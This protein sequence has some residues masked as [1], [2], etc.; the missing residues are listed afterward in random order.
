MLGPLG[1]DDAAWFASNS[2]GRVLGFG[3]R[4]R[5]SAR[6]RWMETARSPLPASWRSVGCV[7]CSLIQAAPQPIKNAAGPLYP[8]GWPSFLSEG[9]ADSH[10]G[11]LRSARHRIVAAAVAMTASDERLGVTGNGA[12]ERVRSESVDR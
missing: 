6:S 1:G 8:A 12:P 3:V 10:R 2:A 11:G 7:A 5:R 4:C 9:F